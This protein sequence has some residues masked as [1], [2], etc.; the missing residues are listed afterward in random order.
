MNDLVKL[1]RAAVGMGWYCDFGDG[2]IIH[3]AADR[4]EQL[5]SRVDELTRL[6]NA[7]PESVFP[8]YLAAQNMVAELQEQV[9][10]VVDLAKDWQKEKHPPVGGPPYGSQFAKQ[11]LAAIKGDDRIGQLIKDEERLIKGENT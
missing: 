5:Q 11:L 4:I 9:D 6:L 7:S 3:Q 10:H 2:N 1:L 8:R